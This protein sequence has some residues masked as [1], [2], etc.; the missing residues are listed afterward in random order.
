[1][2]RTRQHTGFCCP[3][4]SYCQNWISLTRLKQ[5]QAKS[6]CGFPDGG[7]RSR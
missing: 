1:M 3:F 2:R 6:A 5:Q 7:H 4:G